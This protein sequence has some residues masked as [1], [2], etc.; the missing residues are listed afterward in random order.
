ME[1]ALEQ[2]QTFKNEKMQVILRIAL[3]SI[4][5]MNLFY[6]YDNGGH[7]GTYSFFDVVALP[8]VVIVL[9]IFYYFIFLK[10]FPF[11]YQNVRI[12]LIMILDIVATIIAFYLVGEVGIYYAGAL[13][14][15]I[16]GYGTRYGIKI[17]YITYVTVILSWIALLKYSPY[18]QANIDV[19]IGWL[20]A[21][22]VLPLYYFKLISELQK[23][24][25]M[26]HQDVTESTFRAGHDS[27]TQLPNR[28]LFE[29]M[30]YESVERYKLTKEKFAL[31]FIDLDGFKKINDV[32]GHEMGDI[33]LIEAS[34]RIREINRFSARMGG[35]EFVSIVHY[36]DEKEL[37]DRA[38]ALLKRI[39]QKCKDES[40]VISVSIGIAKYPEDSKSTYEIKKYS[41]EAMYRAKQQGKNR[42]CFF[43]EASP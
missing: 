38:D 43:M 36:T 23:K 30:L 7:F 19:G 6:I 34:K 2:K 37:R 40:I 28:N 33:V 14:W 4:F 17:G 18:W 24:I 42:Y 11:L 35:D 41:D 15:F 5:T 25:A 22:V 20:V 9:N 29:K 32:H 26:L 12:I 10:H 1:L 13:L 39:S 16:I 8:L 21:Y 27:L 3:V 31:F